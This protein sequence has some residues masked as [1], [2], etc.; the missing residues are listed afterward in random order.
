M[1]LEGWICIRQSELCLATFQIKVCTPVHSPAT[2]ESG[3]DPDKI[4]FRGSNPFFLLEDRITFFRGFQHHFSYDRSGSILF[5]RVG[6]VSGNLNPVQQISKSKSAPP[7]IVQQ[8][9]EQVLIR[10]KFLF[11]D[12][13]HIFIE[14]QVRIQIFF[15]MV[16]D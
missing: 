11:K 4:F 12:L 13:E 2:K 6:S 5:S 7:Y 9:K 10:I 8:P 16:S 3:L 14:N 1:V 15:C